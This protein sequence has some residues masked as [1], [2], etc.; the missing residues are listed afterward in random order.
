MKIYTAHLTCIG[1]PNGPGFSA[2][3][4]CSELCVARLLNKFCM[5]LIKPDSRS[6]NTF[7]GQSK[8]AASPLSSTQMAT[9]IE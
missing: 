1:A 5:R 7:F 9:K 6:K 2:P 3:I 4:K 8:Q